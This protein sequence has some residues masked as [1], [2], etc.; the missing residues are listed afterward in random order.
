M[1]EGLFEVVIMLVGLYLSHGVHKLK[2]RVIA[3]EMIAMIT[4]LEKE[5]DND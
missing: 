2:K 4:I 5:Q 3:L 1:P